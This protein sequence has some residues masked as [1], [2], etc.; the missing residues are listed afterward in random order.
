[1]N[2][3]DI[4]WYYTTEVRGC[5]YNAFDPNNFIQ[6][7][8]SNGMFGMDGLNV[9]SQFNC[10]QTNRFYIKMQDQNINGGHDTDVLSAISELADRINTLEQR[11]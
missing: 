4:D 6:N 9:N 5:M 7:F 8:R 11:V 3:N 2:N 1:M 10:N